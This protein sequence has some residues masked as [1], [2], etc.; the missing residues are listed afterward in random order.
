MERRA[1]ERFRLGQLPRRFLLLWFVIVLRAVSA[2][3]YAS[4]LAVLVTERGGS[5]FAGGAAISTFLLAGAVGS[6]FAGNLSDR[7][8]RRKVLF[9][10]M[11][12]A[13][14]LYLVF[15]HGPTIWMLPIIGLAGLL[16]LSGTP[17][18]V[19]A[20]QECLPGRTGL[21][22]GLVMGL[23]WGM[24]GL[25]LTPIGWLADQLGLIPV[26]SAVAFLPLIGSLLILFYREPP[27]GGLS[28][29]V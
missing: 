5:A 28:K 11:F 24:G 18:G 1:P 8:G 19:V 4:F 9:V 13:A 15:L 7:W 22:S 2:T 21:V 6:F 12:V 14:P 29:T 20:A 10:S 25:A 16:D 17:V 26:M 27:P 23:A 3:A